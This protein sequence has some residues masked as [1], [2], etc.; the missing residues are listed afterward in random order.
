MIVSRAVDRDGDEAKV[1]RSVLRL[2][3]A[4]RQSARDT[5]PSGAALG[6]LATLYR[7]GPMSAVDLSRREGLQPQSLSR[8]LASLDKAGLIERAIDPADRRRHVI[9]IT[10]HG[11]AALGRSMNLRRRWLATA[12]TERLNASERTALLRA[13]DLML[14]MTE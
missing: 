7:W 5:E 1:I 14:R 2:A 9:A 3:R 4:L 6:L 10:E 11:A 8:I 13:A 12:M